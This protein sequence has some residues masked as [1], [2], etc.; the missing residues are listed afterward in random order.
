M[1][2]GLIFLEPWGS[3]TGLLTCSDSCGIGKSSVSQNGTLPLFNDETP[4]L[5]FATERLLDHDRLIAIAIDT[6]DII[7][8]QL[9]ERA[10]S[11]KGKNLQSSLPPFPQLR[12]LSLML[13]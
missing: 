3:G 13:R 8:D 7:W 6:N 11:R 10:N 9:T 4:L 12:V 1:C 5:L 2:E